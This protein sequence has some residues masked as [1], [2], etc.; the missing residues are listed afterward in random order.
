LSYFQFSAFQHTVIIAYN[1]IEQAQIVGAGQFSIEGALGDILNE[2]AGPFLTL[3]FHTLVF[4]A[5]I[6]KGINRAKII[7]S[8]F[9]VSGRF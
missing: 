4:S 3:P 6:Y 8:T 5:F 2:R 7:R 9:L 1:N